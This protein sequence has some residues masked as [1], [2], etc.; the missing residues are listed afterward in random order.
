MKFSMT[1][2][3]IA[4][5]VMAGLGVASTGAMAQTFPDFTVAEGSVPGTPTNTFVADKITGNYTEVFT[6]TGAGTFAVSLLWNAGQYV[7]QDG[8]VPQS[9]VGDQFLGA[10][11][12]GGGYGMYALY[13]ATG[14]FTTL[15]GVTTFTTDP[16]VGTLSL[17]IDAF[18]NTTF[19]APGTGTGSF[20]TGNII[21]DYLIATGTP[22]A[23]TGTLNP[24]LPTCGPNALNPTGSGINCGS[25][26][27]TSDFLLT[28][29]GK[30]YFTNPDPFYN[31]TFQSGQLNLFSVSATQRING[32]LDVVFKP[33]AVPEPATMAL[34]GLG[35]LGM[36]LG[37]RNRK[38][39]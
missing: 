10:P 30:N 11:N 28:A 19:T 32:S 9:V 37:R 36:G 5:A 17:F 8:T 25:F 29:L 3:L 2:A 39:S 7:G 31:V 14:K 22:E 16:G 38:V 1:K 26:G 24:F 18:K 6:V 21:D 20:T 23:G 33:A 35:L 15:G 34:V 12:A 4:G 13:Q 27:T